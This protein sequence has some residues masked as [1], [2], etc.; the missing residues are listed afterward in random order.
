MTQRTPVAEDALVPG[1]DSATPWARANQRLETL[2]R[3]RT[4]WLSTIQ[5]DGRPHIM[6]IIGLWLNGA[7]YFITGEST[8]KGRNLAADSRC[9]LSFSS[10]SVPS[11]DVSVQG[12]ARKVTDSRTIQ[13]VADGYG[14]KMSW[15]LTVRDG[16]VF[17]QNAP[18]AGPPPYAVFELTPRTIIG[19]PG[20]TG[21]EQETSEG[22]FTPTRW[23]F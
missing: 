2:E 6:P 19:L 20:L 12:D 13:M 23:R 14:S 5:P 22:P 10:A 11:L 16:L 21:M 3:N 17:G 8:R 15:Q 4:Y 7:F 18:T 9:A 1:S